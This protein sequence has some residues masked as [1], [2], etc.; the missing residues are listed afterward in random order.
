MQLA[1]N[2]ELLW[3][4]IG[5]CRHPCTS[6][7]ALIILDK[8]GLLLLQQLPL[9]PQTPFDESNPTVK[10]FCWYFFDGFCFSTFSLG[11]S[12]SLHFALMSQWYCTMPRKCLN[13]LALLGRSRLKMPLEVPHNW[14]IACFTKEMWVMDPFYVK[15]GPHSTLSQVGL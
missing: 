14:G 12:I 6:Q 13:S 5:L 8:P 2:P 4:P 7:K 1:Y 3:L 9:H 11:F 15:G 10:G